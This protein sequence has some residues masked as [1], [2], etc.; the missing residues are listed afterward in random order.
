[1]FKHLTTMFKHHTET[2]AR[3]APTEAANDPEYITNNSMYSTNLRALITK[4]VYQAAGTTVRTCATAKPWADQFADATWQQ[5]WTQL[6]GVLVRMSNDSSQQYQ[7]T[8]VPSWKRPS[9]NALASWAE[10]IEANST[11]RVPNIWG[12]PFR[13]TC[14]LQPSPKQTAHAASHGHQHG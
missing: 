11:Y 5:T 3:Q 4:R 6:E 8:R 13:A 14:T 12:L 1:M 2:C 10:C 7:H 9:K